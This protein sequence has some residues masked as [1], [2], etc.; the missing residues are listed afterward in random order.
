MGSEDM[1]D[2]MRGVKITDPIHRKMAA[3]IDALEAEKT[4]WTKLLTD[5]CAKAHAETATA[6][7]EAARLREG[8][9]GFTDPLVC[10]CVPCVGQCRSQESLETILDE[11]KQEAIKLLKE[12]GDE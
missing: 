7:A 6:T 4:T 1:K 9:E 2:I 12:T 11:M 10:G 3:R 5:E 8:L